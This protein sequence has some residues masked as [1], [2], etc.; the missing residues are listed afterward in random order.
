MNKARILI[1]LGK[2]YL[3]YKRRDEEPVGLPL[4]MWVETSTLCNLKCPMCPNKDFSREQ[5]S[6]LDLDLFKRIVDQ[7]AGVVNDMYLHHRGEPFTN[8]NL[9]AMIRYAEAAGIRTRFH[10]NGG[11]MN[12]ERAL[13][14]LDAKPHMVSFS[15]DGFSKVPYE[16][17]RPGATFETTVQNILFLATEKRKRRQKLPYLEVERIRFRKPHPEEN[18]EAIKLLREKFI[19]H[20]VNEVIEK[21]EYEWSTGENS[22]CELPP[23]GNCCT[24]PWYA[25]VVC[26]DGT[27]TPCPQ[28]FW[29]KMNLGDFKTQTLQEIWHG[30]PYRQLRRSLHCNVADLEICRKC[31]RLCRK[32]VGGVPWQYAKTFLVDQ[33]AGYGRLRRMLGTAERS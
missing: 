27:V 31:D 19:S 5:R 24:F 21:A 18:A 30:A 10:T 2:A 23:A 1:R 13:Q 9:F 7:A 8:P 29:A 14:L 25:M 15:V 12:E 28:D 11:I 20:G 32:T 17:M 4:R 6:V 26:A 3:S 16:A 22:N 33:L